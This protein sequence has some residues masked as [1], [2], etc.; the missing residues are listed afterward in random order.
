MPNRLVANPAL[1]D[2]F[3]GTLVTGIR[4][5]ADFVGGVVEAG[6]HRKHAKN[7]YIAQ[8]V[9]GRE[10]AS[11]ECLAQFG[12]VFGKPA[13]VADVATAT[14]FGVA[15]PDLVFTKLVD[16]LAAVAV[17]EAVVAV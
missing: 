12:G 7:Q 1:V 17:V 8:F 2:R 15:G 9:V 14:H 6:M 5:E 3:V 16:I 10:P 11:T 13:T 4:G